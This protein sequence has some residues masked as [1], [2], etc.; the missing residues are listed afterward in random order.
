MWWYNFVQSRGLLNDYP[1]MILSFFSVFGNHNVIDWHK[2]NVKIFFT[3]EN[4]QRKGWLSYSDHALCH[5][6]IDLALGFEYLN[7]DRY[8]RFPLWILYAF[9][10]ESR[11]E[12]IRKRCEELCNFDFDLRSNFAALISSIDELGVRCDMYECL[13]NVSKVDC[14]GALLHNDDSLWQKYNDNKH[15]YLKNYNFNI[16]PE[17]SDTDGYVT[18][19]LFESIA[20]GCIPIYWGSRNNPEPEVFNRDAIIFW[21]KGG[22]NS[23]TIEFIRELNNKPQLLRDFAAQPRLKDT[24]AEIII[25][26]FDELELRLKM[27]I[28]RK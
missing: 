10:P 18:E 22:D 4:V 6:T 13:C 25:K 2:S 21:Q 19:K 16:C 17:N 26:M 1:D 7:N 3:G 9:E 20:A 12:E 24:A 15:Q 8:L 5:K 28:A 11:E 23:K 14:G 27:I